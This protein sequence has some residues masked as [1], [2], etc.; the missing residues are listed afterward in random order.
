MALL[1]RPIEGTTFE[2][3]AM[4]ARVDS[5][6]VRLALRLEGTTSRGGATAGVIFFRDLDGVLRSEVKTSQG[7][8]QAVPVAAG[9]TPASGKLVNP[10][11]GRWPAD[12]AF[13]VLEI[14]RSGKPGTKVAGGFDL[15]FD[16]EPVAWNIKV[17][18][19]GS[20]HYYVGLSGQTDAIDNEYSVTVESFKVY[21]A[22]PEAKKNVRR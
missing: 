9:D 22:K 18:G 13:H 10:E 2:R 12:G 1:E 19:L 8:W 20:R 21:R 17:A 11:T 6:K 4:S 15:Y 5:G 7:D 14:R 16:G 3:L